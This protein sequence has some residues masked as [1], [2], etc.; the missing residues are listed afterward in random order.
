MLRNVPY[1][2]KL[3]KIWITDNENYQKCHVKEDIVHLYWECPN[4]QRLWERLEILVEQQHRTPFTKKHELC[5]LGEGE[6]I[7]RSMPN[8]IL[9][10]QILHPLRQI[11]HNRRRN[12]AS[13]TRETYQEHLK[14]GANHIPRKWIP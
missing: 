12:D 14:I 3:H 9:T 13:R 4:M 7:P 5:L 10:N 11:Q 8:S 6:R 1:K 2:S